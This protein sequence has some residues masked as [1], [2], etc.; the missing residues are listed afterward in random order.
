MQYENLTPIGRADAATE[1]ASGE[2][3]RIALTLIRLALYDPDRVYVENLLLYWL[4]KVDD[5]FLRGVAATGLGHVARI[6]KTLSGDIVTALHALRFDSS[7][8]GKVE[9][10]LEDLDA[11][12]GTK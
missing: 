1:L 7:I 3:E 11:F 5:S 10:A 2:R 12:K 9:D 4:T 8:G 6:H